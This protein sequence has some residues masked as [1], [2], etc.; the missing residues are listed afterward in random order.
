M[1]QHPIEEG[2][3]SDESNGQPETKNI[4]W[5]RVR[6]TD[7]SVWGAYPL[8]IFALFLAGILLYIALAL[9][10]FLGASIWFV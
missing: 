8:S 10:I 3:A 4:K 9:W 1:D 6:I 7:R 5:F 2:P